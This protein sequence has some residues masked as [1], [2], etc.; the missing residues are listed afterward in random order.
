[1]PNVDGILRQIAQWPYIITTDLTKAFHQI[2]LS[3][4]SLKYCGVVTPFKGVRVYTRCAM[5]MPGSETALEEL[6]C[7]VLGDLIQ[8]GTVV[9]LADDLYYGGNTPT[10]LHDNWRE[11][12]CA[13]Q[14]CGLHLGALKTVIAPKQIS[15]LGWIWK[16]GTISASPHRISTLA[17]CDKSTNVTGMRSFIGAFRILSRVLPNSANIISSLEN[18]IAGKESKDSILWTESLSD[19]FR[20]AQE[21]LRHCKTIT[22]PKASD[23]LWIVTD[24]SVKQHGLGATLYVGRNDKMLLGGFFSAKLRNRQMTWLPCEIEALSIATAVKHFAP[25]LVQSTNKACVLTDSKPCVQAYEKLCR[26]EF[27]TSPRVLTYLSTVSQYHVSIRHVSGASILPSDHAS[28]NAPE[29]FDSS[30][31]ICS[32]VRQSEAAVVRPVNITELTNGSARLPYTN[33]S[34]WFQIQ[35]ECSDLRR[36]R[37]HLKQG[38]R[39]SRKL[40]NIKDVKRYLQ[41]A[42]IDKDGLLVTQSTDPFSTK[43]TRIIVPRQVLPGFLLSLHLKLDHPTPHQLK[44]VCR[45]YFFALDIDQAIDHMSANCHICLSLKKCPKISPPQVSSDPP[46]AIGVS[47]AADVIRRERQ[48]IF[49]IRECVTSYTVCLLIP[50]EQKVTLRDHLIQLCAELIPLDGPLA[51]IRTDAAPGFV[52]LTNDELLAKHRIAIEIGNRKNHN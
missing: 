18:E 11:L 42:N 49:L 6:M 8:K 30:C 38:T 23:Q 43:Q 32:F 25:Y 4:N 41:V 22:L 34:T 10:E 40:T 48:L 35:S 21:A 50:D 28:R 3:R 24:G 45:R 37:A 12:L 5:G 27:S 17:S 33:R 31:Q 7:R 16:N 44:S 39:P 13:L 52:A 2:P 26:G 14:R 47:F 20:K 9:K 15:V 36:T 1:M 19:H 29:C 46:N 51:V